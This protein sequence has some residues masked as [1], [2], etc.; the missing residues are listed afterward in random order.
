MAVRRMM[1]RPLKSES[2]SRFGQVLLWLCTS[3][4][5]GHTYTWQDVSEHTGIPRSWFDHVQAGRATDPNSSRL[6]ALASF[7]QVD[8]GALLKAITN[9]SLDIAATLMKGRIERYDRN[10]VAWFTP[11]LRN[12]LFWSAVLAQAVAPD[13]KPPADPYYGILPLCTQESFATFLQKMEFAYT[14]KERLAAMVIA[15]PAGLPDED[16]RW[17]AYVADIGAW[18]ERFV[19]AGVKII[20]VDRHLPGGLTPE[21]RKPRGKSSAED[22]HYPAG[23]VFI[24]PNDTWIGTEAAKFLIERLEVR[25][26]VEAPVRRIGIIVDDVRLTPQARRLAAARSVIEKHTN[27]TMD[28]QLVQAGKIGSGTPDPNHRN[29]WNVA[30]RITRLLGQRPY[31]VLCGSSQLAALT[32][33]CAQALVAPGQT[34]IVGDQ[35]PIA[36]GRSDSIYFVPPIIAMDSAAFA[37]P[38][39][40]LGMA[41]YEPRALVRAIFNAIRDWEIYAAKGYHRL[42][43]SGEIS[44]QLEIDQ[45]IMRLPMPPAAPSEAGDR[46]GRDASV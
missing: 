25:F 17:D 26:G 35:V 30:T 20:V 29:Y 13:D 40:K 11:E 7:F 27:A 21:G 16:A 38:E 37:R 22:R 3:G 24:G 31:G 14:F 34:P 15:A 19:T 39:L 10:M 6:T 45:A 9:P 43:H 23:V 18:L 44:G 33:I 4:Y 28:E 32:S 12:S 36:P 46:T 2:K 42:E 1:G 8:P 41:P 5:G